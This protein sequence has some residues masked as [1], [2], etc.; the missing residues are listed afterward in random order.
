[1]NGFEEDNGAVAGMQGP[2]GGRTWGSVAQQQMQDRQGAMLDQAYQDQKA[3]WDE[4][5]GMDDR[6]RQAAAQKQV[7]MQNDIDCLMSLAMRNN[8]VVSQNLIDRFN[9]KFGFDPSK[10]TGMFSAKF[11]G[12][13]FFGVQM[14]TGQMDPLGKPILQDHF[15]NPMDQWVMMNRNKAAFTD[16]IRGMLRGFLSKHY[17]DVELDRAAGIVTPVGER[18]PSGGTSVPGWWL[19]GP[20]R[21]SSISGFGSDGRGGYTQYNSDESTGYR[22]QATDGGTRQQFQY[23]GGR[24]DAYTTAMR[25]QAA[26]DRASL[27][28]QSRI[29]MNNDNNA[30]RERM[31]REKLAAQRDMLA[32]RGANNLDVA[33]LRGKINEIGAAI[34]ASGGDPEKLKEVLGMLGSLGDSVGTQQSQDGAISP[35]VSGGKMTGPALVPDAIGGGQTQGRTYGTDADRQA[36]PDASRAA[37]EAQRRAATKKDGSPVDE[38][39]VAEQEAKKAARKNVSSVDRDEEELVNQEK[40][41]QKALVSAG[42]VENEDGTFTIADWDFLP[43]KEKRSVREKTRVVTDDTLS[44][45]KRAQAA[46]KKYESGFA[47]AV[48]ARKKELQKEHPHDAAARQRLLEEFKREYAAENDPREKRKRDERTAAMGDAMMNL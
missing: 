39:A 18:T 35:Q 7:A 47:K 43:E 29:Q 22:L 3:S 6:D 36:A 8:G 32:Q 34:R 25:E 37:Q 19:N 4:Y 5:S 11:D 46:R 44:I 20:R 45:Q 42:G 12:R 16:D 38:D 1:M 10:G 30:S 21:R 28:A 26:N 9:R 27:D 15:A 33:N 13:G 31:E 14:G 17:S 41:R 23:G 24:N 48:E 40:G 2:F